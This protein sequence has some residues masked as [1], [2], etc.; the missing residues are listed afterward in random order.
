MVVGADVIFYI[1][2]HMV[3][4]RLVHGSTVTDVCIVS[5]SVEVGTDVFLFIRA[6]SRLGLTCLVVVPQVGAVVP[7]PR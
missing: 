5:L 2:T 4:P 6:L 1:R 3:V 7:R